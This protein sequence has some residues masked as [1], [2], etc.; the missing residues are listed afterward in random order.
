L[1]VSP[2][3]PLSRSGALIARVPRSIRVLARQFMQVGLVGLGGFVIDV[4]VFNLLRWTMP[5]LG[6]IIPKIIST[7]LAIAANW[8]GNRYWT[9]RRER[10]QE[11]VREGAEFLV[12]SLIGALIPLACLGISHYVLGH[13]SQLADNISANVI[14]LILGTAFRFTCYR[15]W[16]FNP[17]RGEAEDAREPLTVGAARQTEGA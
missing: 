16:V 7:G 10:R 3:R 13:T 9:F 2:E 4:G 14:G 8:L 11:V 15:L 12:V 1:D 5:G 17:R 6:P